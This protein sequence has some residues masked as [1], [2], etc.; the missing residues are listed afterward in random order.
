MRV[1]IFQHQRSDEKVAGREILSAA[2]ARIIETLVSKGTFLLY[3]KEPVRT[4]FLHQSRALC[5]WLNGISAG[6]CRKVV[7][8]IDR[9]G[10]D[11]V[12]IDGSNFG[13]LAQAIKTSRPACTVI[14]FFHNVEAK[15][16]WDG[17][18]KKPGIKALGILVA[19]YIAER[20]AVRNSDRIICLNRR[21]G[22]LLRK[23]YGRRETDIIPM[24]I[25]PSRPEHEIIPAK[26]IT[27]GYAL[28]VG[29]AFYANLSGI[30]WFARN[31]APFVDRK[32]VVVGQGFEQYR[33]DL[34]RFSNIEVIGTVED[35]APWYLGADFV[36]AP[37]FEGSGMK[38]KVAEAM[39][40]GKPIAATPEALVG[41]E[42]VLPEAAMICEGR[43]QFIRAFSTF[44]KGA[45]GTCSQRI[46]DLF[47]MHFSED[48]A[49]RRFEQLFISVA[50]GLGDA[51]E[52]LQHEK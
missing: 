16:F 34:E 49:T 10:I 47:A 6:E 4:S 14:T 29:G 20:N 15:F 31:V 28:F 24:Y 48:A 36:V 30:R 19:N 18:K 17:F 5:G 2:N 37:I 46:K 25:R 52:S 8:Y 45:F 26:R 38:T 3:A 33:S 22:R 44:D 40:Y 23:L 43:E 9:N 11:T 42:D 12:Y 32:T 21:D 35:V 41:Y 1:L 51:S 39:M 13:R 27:A 50:R 7:A